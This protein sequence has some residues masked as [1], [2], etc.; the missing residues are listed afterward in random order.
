MSRDSICTRC[1]QRGH[2]ASSCKLPVLRMFLASLA[3]MFIVACGGGGGGDVSFAAPVI[4]PSVGDKAPQ[5]VNACSVELYGDSIMAGNY[6]AETPALTLKRMRP[7]LTVIDKALAGTRLMVLAMSF[8]NDP[9]SSRYI[10]IENG[11]IDS[12]G[13]TDPAVFRATLASMVDYV[14]AEGRVPVLTGLSNLWPSPQVKAESIIGRAVFDA[15]IRE[16]AADKGVLFADWGAARFDGA[17]DVPDGVHPV[18]PYSDRLVE[19]LAAVI[20]PC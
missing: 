2:T 9:R 11:N 6:T 10:V 1:L 3:L 8:M 5:P 13:G 19:R 18:K 17:A 16:L 12:W 7:E 14:R 20:P 15:V 4:Q